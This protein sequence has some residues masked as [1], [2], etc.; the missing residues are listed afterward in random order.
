MAETVQTSGSAPPQQP[1]QHTQ[2]VAPQPILEK[3]PLQN[4]QPMQFIPYD[5]QQ[6]HPL[7]NPEDNV[8][9]RPFSKKWHVAKIVLGSISIVASIVLWAI[10]IVVLAQF[11]SDNEYYYD[12]WQLTF[13]VGFVFTAAGLA[14]LW[15]AAEFITI[16]ASSTNHGIHPGANVAL[17]LIIW[18]VAILAV[19]F[20]ATF[21]SFDL[22]QLSRIRNNSNNS[23]S[24]SSY[25]DNYDAPTF[26]RLVQLE[27]TLLA[28][29]A[30][31]VVLHFVLF[32]RACVE[33]HRYNNSS[34]V[35]RTVYVQ[36]PVQMPAG[37]VP[38]GYFAYQPLP[39]QP[40]PFVQQPQ[41]QGGRG[42]PAQPPQAHLYG[43]YAPAPVPGQAPVFQPQ[44][45]IPV[46]HPT[47]PA[48]QRSSNAAATGSQ[49]SSTT[50]VSPSAGTVSP[51][52]TS[53]RR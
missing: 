43:Y 22:D 34:L 8:S 20:L 32:V 49:G 5:P 13:E 27:E 29:S 40:L 10:A 39:G 37:Q 36:V 51:V 4:Q 7:L 47:A 53:D 41:M 1:H 46:S 25:Y 9:E 28:F 52:T 21:V 35:T 48:A 6:Q 45:Q 2:P 23:G 18:L 38:V 17:H 50:P 24:G 11:A 14:I 15:Q 3:M 26:A 19:G 30:L 33:T 12:S 16:W 44:H 31:L 42:V